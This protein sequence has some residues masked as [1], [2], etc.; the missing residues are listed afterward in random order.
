MANGFGKDAFKD[1]SAKKDLDIKEQ[2]MAAFGTTVRAWI[3]ITEKVTAEIFSGNDRSLRLLSEMLKDG[4]SLKRKPLPV[5]AVRQPAEKLL[6]STLILAT[7]RMQGFWP[8]L[9]DTNKACSD[10][11]AGTKDWTNPKDL[12]HLARICIGDRQYHMLA[13][14]GSYGCS[15]WAATGPGTPG[16]QHCNF[17]LQVPPGLKDIRKDTTIPEWGKLNIYT[18]IDR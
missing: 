11:G 5:S 13:V 8:V 17:K 3:Y 4:N 9:V 14:S 15:S 18:M 7:W 12:L 6:Y 2:V 1:L 16:T 10:M